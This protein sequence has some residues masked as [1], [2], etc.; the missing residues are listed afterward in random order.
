[1]LVEV[2][3]SDN[4]LLRELASFEVAERGLH[5]YFPQIIN[6]SKNLF[7]STALFERLF[8]FFL[9]FKPSFIRE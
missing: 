8:I 9:I 6:N 2:I 1:M 3:A 4:L 7:D 5:L